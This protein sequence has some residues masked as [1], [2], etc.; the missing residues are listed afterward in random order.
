MSKGRGPG[1]TSVLR[2]SVSATL[3]YC[4]SVVTS[5]LMAPVIVR[6]FGAEA[7][8][9]WELML[10]L[11]GYLGL[12]DLGVT[13]ALIRYIAVAKGGDDRA[14]LQRVFSA[15]RLFCLALAI[16]GAL[17]LV[18]AAVRPDILFNAK[19]AASDEIRRA[20]LL[21]SIT[22]ALNYACAAPVC[23][24]LGA[25]RYTLVNGFRIVQAIVQ[26][27]VSYYVLVRGPS[28]PLVALATITACGAA[29]E[30]AFFT[31]LLR[32][33]SDAPPLTLRIPRSL[34]V[35]LMQFGAKSTAL[36][37][38]ATLMRSGM[39][40][41]V[42]H[43]A[44]VG[45]VVFFVF[46]LRLFEM[47]QSLGQAIGIPL[48][49]YF[50]H[51][52]GRANGAA[53]TQQWIVATR[54]LQF[55]TFGVTL[56]VL[57]LGLPF[58]ARWLGADYAERGATAFGLLCVAMLVQS[59]VVNANRLLV[60]AGRHGAL[61]I[62]ALVV[63]SICLALAVPL[64]ARFG[65]AAAAAAVV[66]YWSVQSAVELVLACRVLGIKP[67]HHVSTTLGRYGVPFLAGSLVFYAARQ[68]AYPQGYVEM[69]AHGFAGGSVYALACLITA[70]S[71]D[72]RR[73]AWSAMKS[74]LRFS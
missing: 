64:V 28:S 33:R 20:L 57:W 7:Y 21:F 17:L 50:A 27:G 23:Y 26:T 43:A 10:G 31:V 30:L 55:V 61:A 14:Q 53:P 32:V 74:R 68:I 49:P 48:T 4:T 16:I 9:V 51:A 1:R 46:P 40:F 52:F 12:L 15:G 3:L 13:P 54:A 11:V 38:A 71:A 34:L 24:L 39:L 22:F 73:V 41:V 47:S 62:S 66:G 60:S 6:S 45:Q 2:N 8:G 25:Q 59:A 44:G 63:G 42:A 56:S 36:V 18:L 37:A 35:D 69:A 72:E 58:L 70:V 65:I 67:A 19:A 5:L 29:V